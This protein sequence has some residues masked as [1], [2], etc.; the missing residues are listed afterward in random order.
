MLEWKKG[1]AVEMAFL[2]LSFEAGDG[3]AVECVPTRVMPS[4]GRG[5][6]ACGGLLGT[7][8]RLPVTGRLQGPASA[9]ISPPPR[10][11]METLIFLG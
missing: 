9:H 2:P 8:H 4:A 7:A 6:V 10:C 1:S 11:S 3:D 5:L